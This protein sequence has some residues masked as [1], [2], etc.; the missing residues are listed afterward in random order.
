MIDSQASTCAPQRG[1]ISFCCRTADAAAV[2]GHLSPASFAHIADAGH[3]VA[4]TPRSF[5]SCKVLT[6]SPGASA[7]RA[8]RMRLLF[9]SRRIGGSSAI[10][11]GAWRRS[12]SCV[13]LLVRGVYGKGGTAR[14]SAESDD[15]GSAAQTL[16][17]RLKRSIVLSSGG[18]I[19]TL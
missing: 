1:F 11:L 4:V 13:N 3:L 10:A 17:R 5:S 2:P 7:P 9:A 12:A 8:L 15:R 18:L 6:D 14:G 16:G 19:V